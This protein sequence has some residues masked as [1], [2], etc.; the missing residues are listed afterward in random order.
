MYCSRSSCSAPLLAN[1]IYCSIFSCFL[2]AFS[3]AASSFSLHQLSFCCYFPLIPFHLSAAHLC[4]FLHTFSHHPTAL[5]RASR[6]YCSLCSCWFSLSFFTGFYQRPVFYSWLAVLAICF[7]LV[8][9]LA[10][11]A[12]GSSVVLRNILRWMYGRLHS[13]T[14]CQVVIFIIISMRTSNLTQ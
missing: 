10:Y 9:C 2:A 1:S 4:Y 8:T 12:D 3:S 5:F 14:C 11:P 7:L 13:V 6:S